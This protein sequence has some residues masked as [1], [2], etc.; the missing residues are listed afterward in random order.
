MVW[1]QTPY[2][3]PLVATTVFLFAFAAYLGSLDRS[4]W[5]S[6]TT[7]GSLLLFAGGGWVGMYTLRLSAATLPGKLLWLRLEFV[8][9]LA[10][11]V[12]WLAYVVRYAGR[13]DWLTWRVFG[14]LT[15][16]AAGV[17]LLVLTDGVHHQVFREYGLAQVGSFAVFDP[18]YGPVFAV[19]LAFTYTLLGA[20]LLF[21]ATAAA[22]ALGVFRWQIALLFVFAVAPGVTGILY[23]TGNTP[24]PGLNVPALSLVVS[25]AAVVVSFARFQWME[26]TPIARDQSL[27]SMNEA[28]VVLDAATRIIDFNPAAERILSGS[29]ADLVGTPV[30][31]A[32]PELAEALDGTA[33]EITSEVR[34]ELTVSSDGDRRCLD[35]RV[36]PVGASVSTPAGYTVLFHDITARK[37][38]EKQA[39]QRRR[40]IEELHRIA[41][42]LTAART[43]EEVFQRAVDGGEE[44]LGADV[45]RLAVEDDGSLVPAASSGDEPVNRYDPQP[46]DDG[47]AGVTFQSNAPIVIDDL[48]YIRG[49]AAAGS[50]PE[51]Y[52]ADES[53]SVA[54]PALPHRA[55]LSAPID[56]IGTIQALATEPGTF[57][58]DDRE[59][60]ELL[61]TH[62]ETAVQR[63]NAESELRR[64]RD[65]LEE[66][67]GVVSHDLQNPLNVAQGRVELLKQSPS[68]VSDH[69]EPID[70]ALSRIETIVT[71]VLALAREG[72]VVGDVEAVALETCIED[73]WATV[74]TG[75]AVLEHPNDLG[76]VDADAGRL[77]QLFENLFRNSVE[78]GSTGA[79]TASDGADAGATDSAADSDDGATDSA[80]DS[81]DGATD[82]AADSDDDATDSAA[83]S[84]DDATDPAVT[85]RVG[86]I[87]DG[88]GFYVEDDGPGIPPDERD[89]IFEHGYTTGSTG[90][91]L[92]LTIVDRIAD[93]H[94]WTITVT[95]SRSGGARFEIRTGG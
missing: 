72:E 44:V 42:D 87:D 71:D 76:T 39:E 11:S 75:S 83:D 79:R 57:S 58:D 84:D 64:E 31:E 37:T 20:S 3:I 89:A 15:A 40:K 52:L 10:L 93:A 26:M 30:T 35:V 74:D 62:I 13:T 4:E 78:H 22:H 91:G 28:V 54:D 27:E 59:V 66:F 81:D 90:T 88:A 82:S 53:P 1:Q 23:V 46:V 94:G 69:V 49:T 47:I 16:I 36:S 24:V 68:Q 14:P 43:Q 92:G 6:G 33:D 51:S 80:A 25:T 45:C 8:P 95:D 77:R 38:A 5:V 50:Y 63:A 85:V 67:A 7:L 12:I 56:G 21:L 34:T 32:L 2:T 65:R 60:L 41:R 9:V 19:Y 29:A 86:R 18:V 70:R 61:T 17:E 55:L 73:A 48:G